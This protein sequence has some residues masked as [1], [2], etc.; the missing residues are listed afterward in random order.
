MLGGL[1]V[2]WVREPVYLAICV[3]VAA[4]TFFLAH[5]PES[6][7]CV[8]LWLD[9]AGLALFCRL[10]AAGLPGEGGRTVEEVMRE[11]DSH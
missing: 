6:R 2:F 1:P 5:I 8:L 7:Y 4:A 10:V 11:L 3:T 9:A